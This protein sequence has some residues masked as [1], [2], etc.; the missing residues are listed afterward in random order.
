MRTFQPWTVTPWPIMEDAL[1]DCE[2]G[3]GR[4]RSVNESSGA[5]AVGFDGSRRIAAPAF[6]R[7]TGDENLAF[8]T[9]ADW[10]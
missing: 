5:S 1:A 2:L 3:S 9:R 7:V 8:H 6:R 4:L 10:S